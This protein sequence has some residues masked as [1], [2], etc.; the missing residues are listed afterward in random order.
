MT[1]YVALPLLAENTT[2]TAFST[3]TR[4]VENTTATFSIPGLEPQLPIEDAW[5]TLDS[6]SKTYEAARP[7]SMEAKIAS[8][9]E[10]E[11]LAYQ[12]RKYEA[13]KVAELSH[14]AVVLG[15]IPTLVT[16]GAR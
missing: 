11:R 10:W 1:A 5:I 8:Y 9:H 12:E 6:L 4:W 7:Q 16:P 14:R 2:P 15:S 13:Q 3:Y